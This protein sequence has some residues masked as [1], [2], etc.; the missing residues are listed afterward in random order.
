LIQADWVVQT[1]REGIRE[2]EA[3]N[4]RLRDE[5]ATCF[6]A[7]MLVMK[8]FDY[9]SKKFLRYVPTNFQSISH[10]RFLAPVANR[11]VKALQKLPIIRTFSGKWVNPGRALIVPA[12]FAPNKEPLVS[13]E[14]VS[15]EA[16][17]RF[18]FASFN[19]GREL[20]AKLG[21]QHLK[22]DWIYKVFARRS[23]ADLGGFQFIQ[24]L[25]HYLQTATNAQPEARTLATSAKVLLVS[26][27]KWISV[28][29]ARSQRSQIYL[30]SNTSANEQLE[31]MTYKLLDDEFYKVMSKDLCARLFITDTLGLTPLDSHDVIEEIIRFHECYLPSKHAG[32][33]FISHAKYLRSRESSISPQQ[34]Q[35]MKFSLRLVDQRNVVCSS[36]AVVLD[37]SSTAEGLPNGTTL[38][39]ACGSAGVSFLNNRY[40]QD[41]IKFLRNFTQVQSRIP[42]RQSGYSI[43]LQTLSAKNQKNNI[44]LHYLRDTLSPYRPTKAESA[45]CLTLRSQTF[46]CEN[47]K[48]VELSSTYLRTS[49]MVS[50]LTPNMDVLDLGGAQDPHAWN[51][52][53][54][55]GVTVQPK[56]SLFVKQLQYYKSG[57]SREEVQDFKGLLDKLYTGLVSHILATPESQRASVVA[58]DLYSSSPDIRSLKDIFDKEALLFVTHDKEKIWAKRDQ[59]YAHCPMFVKYTVRAMSSESGIFTTLSG[60]LDLPKWETAKHLYKE[61]EFGVPSLMEAGV[62]MDVIQDYI[63]RALKSIQSALPADCKVPPEWVSKIFTLPIFP[64]TSPNGITR[65]GQLGDDTLVPDSVTLNEHFKGKV[66]LLDFGQKNLWDILPL[67]KSVRPG[68]GFISTYDDPTLTSVKVGG[69]TRDDI[70]TTKLIGA[71]RLALLRYKFLPLYFRYSTNRE[72]TL[73]KKQNR[74]GGTREDS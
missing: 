45:L 10:D 29:S 62:K 54:D 57:T 59:I 30:G 69:P 15:C 19:N 73:G 37:W 66:K 56:L 72:V 25:F 60:F 49:T 8:K 21:C 31:G 9:L 38:S 13:A 39:K 47:R 55:M 7:A 24:N 46:L 42:I 71:R 63:F 74:G 6:V 61:L 36:N 51:F 44:L 27:G 48:Y 1:S 5:I 28:H 67:F 34:K 50:L 41:D 70:A 11:I 26:D 2:Q 3:W 43:Y 18:D 58:F 53:A 22:V 40:D 14:L 32:S 16:G 23:P 35:R 52:L 12:E 17:F 33:V 4:I 65:P 64:I 20:L 68:L